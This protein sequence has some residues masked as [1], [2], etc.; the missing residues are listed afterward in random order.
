MLGII[1][2]AGYGTRMLELGKRYPKSI[3]P[4]KERPLLYWN[5]NWLLNQGCEEV[6][7][8]VN[9]HKDQVLETIQ[10]YG[11]PAK[12]VEPKSMGGLSASVLS[13][14]ESSTINEDNGV[15]I[16]LG[17]TLVEGGST[18]FSSNFVSVFQVPD[19]ERWCMFSPDDNKFYDKPTEKPPTDLALSGVYFVKSREDLKNLLEEQ[20][21]S[22]ETLRGEL[23]L[24][25]SLSR[26]KDPV[27]PAFLKVLDFGTLHN[28]LGNRRLR[29]SREFNEVSLDEETVTKRSLDRNKIIS[30]ANWYK[31]IPKNVRIHAPMLLGHDF[32]GDLA[33]YEMERV[34]HPTLREVYLFLDRSEETWSS[35]FSSCFSLLGKMGSS[36]VKGTAPLNAVIEKTRSRVRSLPEQFRSEAV[37]KKFL[38]DFES[39]SKRMDSDDNVLV[40]GDF[41]FSNLMWDAETKRV[42]MVDPRGDL[43]GSRFYD[44]A[45]LRHSSLYGYDFIDSELYSVCKGEA[46][47]FD[48][49]AQAVSRVYTEMEKTVFGEKEISYLDLLTASLFLTMIPLHSHNPRNQRLYYDKFR[50]IYKQRS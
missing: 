20:V 24:S 3:L 47:V 10:E 42:I 39:E 44:W 12:A 2:A 8:V 4:Y 6:V 14:I 48:K 5:V 27:V 49:G 21:N 50:Q 18:D 43:Y 34:F 9:H 1:P 38:K 37:V 35:I 15:L 41:C 46:R 16:L 30:E 28:Y 22:E 19:W 29:N 11:L 33:S 40:H 31:G 17:D 13:G 26:L 23:Q 7:V 32:H 36:K 25:T 45:K